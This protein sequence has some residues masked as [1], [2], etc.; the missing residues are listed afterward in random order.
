FGPF[1]AQ[2]QNAIQQGFLERAFVEA[3]K[4]VLAYREIADKEVF[5]GR[6]G[7][8]ITKTRVGLMIPNV[9]PLNPSTNTNLDN[10]LSPQ[11]Y[12]DEQ[13]TLAVY[14]YPQLAPDINLV[15]D[16]TTISAFAMKNSENLG[17]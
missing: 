6:I 4:N 14:Q 11:Q 9:T 7:D 2:L 16:E 1:P 8:T 5:P 15:D 10:G 17:I 3:L 13:Y 12:S